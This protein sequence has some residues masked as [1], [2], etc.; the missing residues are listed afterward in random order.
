MKP[1][2]SNFLAIAA[3]DMVDTQPRWTS[4]KGQTMPIDFARRIFA[5]ASYHPETAIPLP[6]N[7][8]RPGGGYEGPL[9][10][11]K[12]AKYPH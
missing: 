8:G 9:W 10:G 1:S 2:R 5:F 7:L 6:A 12:A 4:G 3:A 11:L